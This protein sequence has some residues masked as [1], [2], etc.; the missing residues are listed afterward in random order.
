MTV[1]IEQ[2]N[3]FIDRVI[4]RLDTHGWCQRSYGSSAG[5]N[6]LSGAMS[7]VS[8]DEDYHTGVMHS[9]SCAIR[10]AAKCGSVIHWNDYSKR[11]LEEVRQMLLQAKKELLS[12]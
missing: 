12:S 7:Q 4:K 9:A 10:V 11:T 6:C 2:R 8:L 3:A 5:P 1:T